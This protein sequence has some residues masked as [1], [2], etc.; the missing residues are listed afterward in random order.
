MVA[1]GVPVL[2]WPVFFEQFITE[3]LVTE[4]LGVGER[5]WPEGAG[6]RSESYEEHE[7]V[8]AEDV[9]QALTTFMI[10]EG[11]GDAARVKVMELAARAHAAV[12]EGGSSHRDLHCLVDDLMAATK[13]KRQT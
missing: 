7:V 2:T 6:L 4:V 13:S 9:A 10:P 12:A 8:P 1:A 3:R 11:R 5:L